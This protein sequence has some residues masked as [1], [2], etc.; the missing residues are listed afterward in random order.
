MKKLF[1]ILIAFIVV[2]PTYAQKGKVT[3]ANSYFTEGKL[4]Q[5]KNAIDEAM[6]DESCADYDKGFLLKGQIYQAIFESKNGNYKK[7]HNAPLDVAWEAYQK[8]IEIDVKK[9]LTKKL[10][11][12][13][14]NLAIDYANQAIACFNK[15][16]YKGSFNSFKKTL[17]IKKTEIYTGG[18][19][20]QIDTTIIYNA[21]TAAYRAQD[22]ASTAEYFR[23]CI[24]MNYEASKSYVMVANALKELGKKEESIKILHEGY[25]KF[26][27]DEYMIVELI[28]YY[29]AGDEPS[30]AE[31]FLDAAIAAD[32]NNAN[33]YR[34]KGSYYEK[35]KNFEKAKEMYTKTV[36]LNPKDFAAQYNLGNI[37]LIAATD[38]HKK[39]QNIDDIDEYNAGVKKVFELYALTL[40]YFE[41]AFELNNKDKNTVMT[42]RELYFKLRNEDPKYKAGYDKF[43]ALYKSM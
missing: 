2:A 15:S 41:K 12:Q 38:Y 9:K 14:K 32:P 13:Y 34:A 10:N 20:P 29:L 21:A 5:A 36:E 40:P 18:K 16:D 17:E 43:D 33:F 25:E 26:P 42:L 28:N 35:S 27:S 8:V 4:D 31:K 30:K 22:Y 19:E 1:L 7:L 11:T 3:Q 24:D 23:K 39:V 6:K 37:N